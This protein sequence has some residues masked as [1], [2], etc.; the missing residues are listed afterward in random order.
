MIR[1]QAGTRSSPFEVS[2]CEFGVHLNGPPTSF[3]APLGNRQIKKLS[4]K[5]TAWQRALSLEIISLETTYPGE[6]SSSMFVWNRAFSACLLLLSPG[7]VSIVPD[8]C[9][10]VLWLH[11]YLGPTQL[12]TQ[13]E[14]SYK[15][16]ACPVS[17]TRKKFF[18]QYHGHL[19]DS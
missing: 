2:S 8:S 3:S 16:M 10:G 9:P 13:T 11:G 6:R 7:F 1:W 18:E 12:E 14:K 4:K 19:R 15:C 5:K 17:I